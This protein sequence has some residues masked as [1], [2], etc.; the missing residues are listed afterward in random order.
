MNVNPIAWA[1][2]TLRLFTRIDNDGVNTT[3][4]VTEIRELPIGFPNMDIALLAKGTGATLAQV[5]DGTI[6]GGNKRGIYATDWQKS[7]A[8]A[9]QVASSYYST[10]GG[11]YANVCSS[12]YSVVAG[13]DSNT[14]STNEYAT[15]GGGS[16]NQCSG[17]FGTISGG[18]SN[19]VSASRAA[20]SGGF[21]NTASSSSSFVGGGQLNSAQTSTH[22]TVCGGSTNT[23]SGQY[24]F[25][26]G[27]LSNT[28]SGGR[29]T[30][31]GGQGNAASGSH[32]FIGGG[33]SNTANNSYAAISG[34][35]GHTAD[36]NRSF[37]SGGARG[38]ARGIT[39][40]HVFPACNIPISFTQGVSQSAILI[41]ARETTN[42]TA[43]VL[44]S[45]TSAADT[46][47][48]VTLPNNSAYYFRGSVIAGVTGA[49]NS[50]AWTFEGAIKRGASAG[51]TAIVGTVILNTIAQDA[52]ASAWSIAI[53]ANT[54]LGC[55]AVTVTGAA[56]TTIRWVAKIET[57][58]MTY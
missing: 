13:G 29:A 3:V 33:E 28:A 10:I 48:Q 20:I 9:T 36:G 25:V 57:T 27:G 44:A 53:T 35:F 47:N 49:G 23:A 19:N 15:I 38:T 42:A 55:I 43:A 5:P 52:G 26:G 46:T 31:A 51:T 1:A 24:S 11:G 56:A 39:G 30:V 17:N 58:E 18:Q 50:K 40:N 7:R 37:I 41:L 8:I 21:A 22:A 32:S 16:G 54:T 34:G 12:G 6:A 14:A 4:P 45:D 2:S